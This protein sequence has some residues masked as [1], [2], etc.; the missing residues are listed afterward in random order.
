M[1]CKLTSSKSSVDSEQEESV[2]GNFGRI[3]SFGCCISICGMQ[4]KLKSRLF[5]GTNGFLRRRENERKIS[6]LASLRWQSSADWFDAE[7][8]THNGLLRRSKSH[9]QFSFL[10]MG[11]TSKSPRRTFWLP[12]ENLSM[13]WL[14]DDRV[15]GKNVDAENAEDYVGFR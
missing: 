4:R 2:L 8:N 15:F 14:G 12:N 5:S 10:G 3:L 9:Q 1:Q 13:R 7:G 11:E 6:W